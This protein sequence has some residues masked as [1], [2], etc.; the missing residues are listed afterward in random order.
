MRLLWILT[1]V[2][3]RTLNI[4][5]HQM[6]RQNLTIPFYEVFK[7]LKYALHTSHYVLILNY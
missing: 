1:S 6:L 2:F 3:T 4:I 5:Y 7:L